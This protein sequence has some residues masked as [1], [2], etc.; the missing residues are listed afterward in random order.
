VFIGSVKQ[1]TQSA[2]SLFLLLSNTSWQH[3]SIISNKKEINKITNSNMGD[4]ADQP[5]HHKY[6]EELLKT[7]SQYL[8]LGS[9][10]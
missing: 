6:C 7:L 2:S 3:K 4:A 8:A 10:M 9:S 5:A 1:T